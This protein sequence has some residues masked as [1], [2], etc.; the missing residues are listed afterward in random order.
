M[1]FL[2]L[3]G[4]LSV[5]I[6]NVETQNVGVI[7]ITNLTLNPP[8]LLGL[9]E[10]D[11]Q[12]ITLNYVCC[13]GDMIRQVM[14]VVT[15]HPNIAVISQNATH[16]LGRPDEDD[17]GPFQRQVYVVIRG[18]RLGYTSLTIH[19]HESKEAINSR[20]VV[21]S[22]YVISV[23]RQDR[24]LDIA[25]RVL[26]ALFVV[27]FNFIMGCTLEIAVILKILK[28]P[29]APTVGFCCQF[30]IMP[31][32]GLALTNIFGLMGGIGLG[33]LVISCSPGGGSSNVWTVLLGGEL[34]LSICMTFLSTV[35]S[36]GM[37]P[38]WLF[39]LAR[40]YV[41]NNVVIPFE[42]IVI[43]LVSIII[44]VTIGMVVRKYKENIALKI[45][46][47]I[48]P[49][50][51]LFIIFIAGFGSYVNSYMFT[52]MA[53]R[54]L[55]FPAGM[56]LPWC[57]FSIGL[58]VAFILRQPFKTAKTIAFET[59]IQNIGIAIILLQFSLPKP[60]GD[61]AVVM[62]VIVAIFTPIPLQIIFVGL[63]IRRCIK[64]RSNPEDGNKD[65]D[66]ISDS[67]LNINHVAGKIAD[68]NG[69]RISTDQNGLIKG[70]QYSN[71]SGGLEN[72]CSSISLS[73]SSFETSV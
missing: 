31:L 17:D 2:I 40:F 36:L 39:A 22:G 16:L 25:F 62:P 71:L 5:H 30:I 28:K 60:D 14:T 63:L 41:S 58:L 29:I 59:G 51:V 37:M 26:T 33:L 32:L 13:V 70:D 69:Y 1:M 11:E 72:R 43:S 20:T 53:E 56:L 47:I 38:L 10:N 52:L 48:K 54:P 35:G 46:K 49:F 3:S 8:S 21:H 55:L 19:L 50:A 44:P 64:K 67:D 4:I 68:T 73:I 61:L 45:S 24:P 18:V 27:M 9:L 23:V 7:A 57:G 34:N 6:G 12:T 15:E 66:Q 65:T 42:N